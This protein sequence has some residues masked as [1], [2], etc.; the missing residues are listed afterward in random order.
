MRVY[1]TAPVYGDELMDK[2]MAMYY[3]LLSY[4]IKWALRSLEARIIEEGGMITIT[5]DPLTPI[6]MPKIDV[7]DFTEDTSE[8]IH[9]LLKNG[10][11]TAL[12][13]FL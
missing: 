13:T 5:P 6:G 12:S 4:R 7:K 11:L 1:F 2:M 3:E 10:D 9:D 8:E